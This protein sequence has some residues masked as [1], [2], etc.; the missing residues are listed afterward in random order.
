MKKR[1]IQFI[2][3]SLIAALFTTACGSDSEPGTERDNASVEQSNNSAP[4][5]IP[6]FNRD[7]AF[8]FVEQQVNFGP[9]NP[10]SDG[11]EKTRDWL[12]SKLSSYGANV[13][14]QAFTANIYT[15][16]SY[17]S[18][19]IIGQFNPDNSR[20]VLLAAHYD[21]RFM[22]EEDTDPSMMSLPIPGADDGASGVG[23]LLEIAR[24]IHENG[25]DLVVDIVF[26]DA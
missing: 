16:E 22:G 14:R 26:F 18:E 6:Q 25:I 13:I 11:I 4:I 10:G 3:V 9:R 15:G 24:L 12:E 7:S 2:A 1:Q 5:S 21:T 20:R 19:N 17:S 8:V 23:V